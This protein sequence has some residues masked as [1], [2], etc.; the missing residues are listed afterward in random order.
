MRKGNVKEYVL[1]N[2]GEYELVSDENQENTEKSIPEDTKKILHTNPFLAKITEQNKKYIGSI[3]DFF[4]LHNDEELQL[5]DLIRSDSFTKKQKK[6]IFIKQHNKWVKEAKEYIEKIEIESIKNIN[7][8]SINKCKNIKF[9]HKF[10]LITGII[11]SLMLLLNAIPIIKITNNIIEMVIVAMIVLGVFSILLTIIQRR[12]YYKYKRN[13]KYHNN[14]H[15][16]I[17]KKLNRQLSQNFNFV[18]KYYLTGYKKNIFSKPQLKINQIK[19]N[20]KNLSNIEESIEKFSK[21]INTILNQNKGL[22]IYYHIPLLSSYIIILFSGGYLI[23][24]LI[25]YLYKLL[26]MKGE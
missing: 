2:N 25:I 20:N 19:V 15:K 23:Y 8:A 1:N 10:Y 9:R 18:K 16:K 6:S 26:F 4:I 11:I 21:Q 17:F 3:E 22:N 12:N 13:L 5:K 24:E 7:N 14:S